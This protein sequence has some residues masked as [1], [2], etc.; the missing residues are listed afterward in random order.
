MID[1]QNFAASMDEDQLKAVARTVMDGYE[2]DDDSRDEWLEKHK[3]Y[4]KLYYQTDEPMNQPWQGS[5]T[6]SMPL[7]VEAVNQY[8]A[9]STKALFP[10]RRF[11]TAIPVGQTDKEAK[12]RA[13]RVG[14]H[15]NFQLMQRPLKG[16]T[17]SKFK[18]HKKQLIQSTALHGTCFTKT[19]PVFSPYM[20]V[21]KNVR[22]QDLI[23]PYGVGPRDLEDIERK[24]E[25]VH[26]TVQ[27]SEYLAAQ[28]Y[29]GTPYFLKPIAPYTRNDM[30]DGPTEAHDEAHGLEEP[31][32]TRGGQPG[33]VFEQHCL[34]DLDEDGLAEAYI[35]TLDAQTREVLRIAPRYVTI[36]GEQIPIEYYTQY[37]FL[38]NPDGAY[39]LG[40]GHL[41]GL[42][43]TAVNKLLR[44]TVDA[45][46]LA[47]IGNM[48]G[49]INDQMGIRGGEIEFKLGLYEKISVPGAGRL[50]DQIW[51]PQFPGP[52]PVLGEVISALINRSDRLAT[53]TEAVTGQTDK[54][55]QPTTVLALLEQS[56]EMFTD[57]STSLLE[58]AED[59]LAKVY[60]LNSWYLANEEYFAVLDDDEISHEG[61]VASRDYT[62]DLQIQPVADP[63]QVTQQQAVN[64]AQAARDI[65]INDPLTASDPTRI[66]P[67]TRNLLKEWGVRNLDEM[68]PPFEPPGPTREDDPE[69]ENAGALMPNPQIPPVHMDQNHTAHLMAHEGLMQDEIYGKRLTPEGKQQLHDHIQMHI[70][71]QYMLTETDVLETISG[72]TGEGRNPEL[73]SASG[74]EVVPIGT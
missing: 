41:I 59:E 8:T 12:D 25:I 62:E 56:L 51:S 35:V 71:F 11:V 34:M 38:E 23:I 21:V 52:Q 18:K 31:G 6:E 63:R 70:A 36:G 14:D 46:E 54:V 58:S 10:S 9:R 61:K 57:F 74:G 5:S 17:K 29:D 48:S 55:M 67:V 4:L 27:R 64:A 15:M 53:T 42:I 19:F 45:G 72:E 49:F 40:M 37:N 26:M 73:A 20:P 50:S 65:I 3:K 7:M 60:R 44:Q 2:M 32:F 30:D 39:G 16:H 43:N 1:L 47:T 33:M 66:Y 68:Y 22:A 28:N 69:L 24:T 13:K